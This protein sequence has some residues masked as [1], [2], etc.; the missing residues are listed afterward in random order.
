[1]CSVYGENLQDDDW[2]DLRR[3][4]AYL[5]AIM[6]RS[7]QN[8]WHTTLYEMRAGWRI[9]WSH[10]AHGWQIHYH[11]QTHR[12]SPTGEQMRV[13]RKCNQR[14]WGARIR[15]TW[16][17]STSLSINTIPSTNTKRYILSVG[18][19]SGAAWNVKVAK[20]FSQERNA[21]YKQ[22]ISRER[23]PSL[24]LVRS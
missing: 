8:V 18:N 13:L 11:T 22:M 16:N 21:T 24:H 20:W 2:G 19:T 15:R 5:K 7:T 12:Q 6:Q 4:I 14:T 9:V 1:M 17:I 3:Y 10:S 23:I